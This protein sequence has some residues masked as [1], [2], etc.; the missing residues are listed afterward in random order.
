[1]SR[2]ESTILALGP[3]DGK[4]Q[5]LQKTLTHFIVSSFR[6]RDNKYFLFDL[7]KAG[8]GHAA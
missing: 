6:F 3:F 8:R 4:C 5:N 7:Q 2:V 1:M